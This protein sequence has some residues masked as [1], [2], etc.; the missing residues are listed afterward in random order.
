MAATLPAVAL[1]PPISE[2]GSD[3]PVTVACYY[4]GNYHPNDPRNEKAKGGGWSEWE[5]V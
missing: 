4:F 1:E 2:P 5:L 3:S